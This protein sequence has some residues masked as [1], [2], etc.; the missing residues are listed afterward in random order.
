MT[1]D[2]SWASKKHKGWHDLAH[3]TLKKLNSIPRATPISISEKELGDALEHANSQL[4]VLE[5]PKNGGSTDTNTNRAQRRVQGI[6]HRDN[7]GAA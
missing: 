7:G 4:T 2:E 5:V 6:P 3:E 1:Q